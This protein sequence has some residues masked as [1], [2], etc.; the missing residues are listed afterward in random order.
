MNARLASVAV[1]VVILVLW[2]GSEAGAQS[3]PD[4]SAAPQATS[5]HVEFTGVAP[6]NDAAGPTTVSNTYDDPVALRATLDGSG[7]LSSVLR[8]GLRT[9]PTPWQPTGPGSF[10]CA[11]GASVALAPTTL[12]D[13]IDVDLPEL[14]P[15]GTLHA[16]FGAELPIS[17]GN[18]LQ[19]AVGSVRSLMVWQ[20][21]CG[22]ATPTTVPPTTGPTTTAPTPPTAV[23]V[24]VPPSGTPT[25]VAEPGS[26]GPG[27]PGPGRPAGDDPG[28]PGTLP[29]TGAATG[30]TLVAAVGLLVAGVLALVTSRRGDG[31]DGEHE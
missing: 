30:L 31:G 26:P 15:S 3:C 7:A 27:S 29:F 14:D 20:Q 12:G 13:G 24:T 16:L 8:I 11:S 17:T 2:S 9:C 21:Q 4:E 18:E 28:R 5:E 25:T 6:G 22:P 10:S 19:G 1:C 23:P